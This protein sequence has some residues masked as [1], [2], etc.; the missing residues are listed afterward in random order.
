MFLI[1]NSLG[2]RT[3]TQHYAQTNHFY[4]SRTMIV[5]FTP[6]HITEALDVPA[7]IAA[8]RSSVVLTPVSAVFRNPFNCIRMLRESTSDSFRNAVR[9]H[10]ERWMVA[11]LY[12]LFE[13]PRFQCARSSIKLRRGGKVVTDVD[14]AILDEATREL[15]LFQLKWQDFRLAGKATLPSCFLRRPRLSVYG[16]IRHCPMPNSRNS[17]LNFGL[18]HSSVRAR[19]NS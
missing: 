16:I 9:K 15:V 12:A 7:G 6:L 3:N 18:M 11:D 1:I 10:R 17:W 14:A 5:S 13:G 19:S 8:M 2:F 4:C